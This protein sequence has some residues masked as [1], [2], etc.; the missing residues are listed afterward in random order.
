MS[1]EYEIKHVADFLKVPED[2]LDACL[3]EFKTF[4]ELSRAHLKV[5]EAV[6][7][8]LGINGRGEVQAF[9]WIDDG[10]GKVTIIM[11]PVDDKV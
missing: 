2:R 3:K 11:Q 7:E 10:E 9:T 5:V 8:E 6:A 4:V 1:N